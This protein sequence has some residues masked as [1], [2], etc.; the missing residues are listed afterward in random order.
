MDASGSGRVVQVAG[1]RGQLQPG[2]ARIEQPRDALARQQLPALVEQRLGLGGGIAG[3][4]L[5]RAQ[6]LDQR[7]HVRAVALER[8]ARGVEC[9]LND[10]HQSSRFMH[11]T[12]TVLRLQLAAGEAR[13]QLDHARGGRGIRVAHQEGGLGHPVVAPPDLRGAHALVAQRLQVV[14]GR[15]LALEDAQGDG[16]VH[17][18]AV[19]DREVL[20]H[21]LFAQLGD[22]A[23]DLRPAL[24]R[25]D[26]DP[27]AGDRLHLH[28]ADARAQFERTI[29]SRA[30]GSSAAENAPHSM[31]APVARGDDGGP[32]RHDADLVGVE[33]RVEQGSVRAVRLRREQ[34][35]GRQQEVGHD[36]QSKQESHVRA[37]A[38][39]PSSTRLGANV[40]GRPSCAAT[41]SPEPPLITICGSVC[42]A[43][44]QATLDALDR[45]AH[46]L[47]GTAEDGIRRAGGKGLEL[48]RQAREARGTAGQRFGHQLGPR[49]DQAAEELAGGGE[50]VDG[51]CGADVDHHASAG[52]PHACTDQCRPAVGAEL[53]GYR[54]AAHHAALLAAAHDPLRTAA[55]RRERLL[56][57]LAHLRAGHAAADRALRPRKHVQCV[58]Q[59]AR[60]RSQYGAL[61]DEATILP[62]PPLDAGIAGVDSQDRHRSTRTHPARGQGVLG[63]AQAHVAGLE[64]PQPGGG[65]REQGAVVI[66]AR[67]HC[68]NASSSDSVTHTG[69][70]ESK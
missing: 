29:A 32:R 54:V 63:Q 27:P 40:T 3:A 41:R 59:L 14:V 64:A 68:A 69:W 67:H 55:P 17:L 16:V 4:R 11:P 66:D 15:L 58:G 45:P 48:A 70:P 35:V 44:S 51:H 43:A 6:A 53:F 28:G 57:L 22:P 36:H 56:D 18:P 19:L 8:L 49:Q 20:V 38:T 2:R 52:V 62:Q 13:G 34:R 10:R 7:Q 46:R 60:A 25:R 26:I 1:Q 31:Q 47:Q 33:L 50:R 12:G 30:T 61:R 24:E 5:E 39:S 65:L 9:G 42:P 21:T 23:L 37:M